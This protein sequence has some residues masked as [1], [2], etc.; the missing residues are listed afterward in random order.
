MNSSDRPSYQLTRFPLGSLRELVALA[1]PLAISLVSNGL[2]CFCDRLYLAQY[3]SDAMNASV[4][5][6]IWYYAITIT[7]FSIAETSE[8]F[9]GRANGSGTRANCGKSVWQLLFIII[10]LSLPVIL[11]SKFAAPW[12]FTGYNA[13]QETDYFVTLMNFALF[14]EGGI[15]LTGFFIAIG[16]PKII[17]LSIIAANLINVILDPIFIFG[18]GPIPE[19]GAKG[20]AFA[21]GI[22]QVC[23]FGALLWYFLKPKMRKIYG[24]SLVNFDWAL[25]KDCLRVALPSGFARSVEMLAHCVFLQLIV[26]VGADIMTSFSVTHSIYSLIFFATE[27]ISK[28]SSAVCANVFG[29]KLERKLPSVIFSALRLSGVVT[30]FLV[31]LFPLV[32]QYICSLF[33]HD[34]N[35]I[36]AAYDYHTDILWSLIFLS[37]CFFFDSVSFIFIGFLT[38]AKDTRFLMIASPLIY[39]GVLVPLAA[40]LLEPDSTTSAYAWLII[41]VSLAAG[42]VILGARALYRVKRAIADSEKPLSMAQNLS[43]EAAS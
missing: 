17:T 33:L 43:L 27:A 13:A 34:F 12:V 32:S 42:A 30:I 37:I 29:A 2:M 7:L 39:W 19:M 1:L 14:S 9:V 38:A 3:S 22:A 35:P 36:D 41:T 6:V 40:Y 5:A 23:Q 31:I 21:T 8:V 20:A 24:T 26:R 25:L 16:K 11:L 10:A 15:C 28:S 4:N 18:F